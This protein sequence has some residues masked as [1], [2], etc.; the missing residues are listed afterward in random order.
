LPEAVHGKQEQKQQKQHCRLV[1]SPGKAHLPTQM[2]Y[3]GSAPPAQCIS[4]R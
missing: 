1:T 2:P 3:E 4:P